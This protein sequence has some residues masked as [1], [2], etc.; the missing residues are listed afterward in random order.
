[1]VS[2][3]WATLSSF[4]E[5]IVFLVVNADDR[6]YVLLNVFGNKGPLLWRCSIL[7]YWWH[8]LVF[9]STHQN[10]WTYTWASQVFH[11]YKCF[12]KLFQV[13][14]E[15]AILMKNCKC[16]ILECFLEISRRNVVSFCKKNIY[17]CFNTKHLE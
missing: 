13:N 7:L 2:Y 11:E 3:N 1:M 16:W 5:T 14:N 17:I 12:I 8:F 4:S 9:Y 6:M 10:D 15:N